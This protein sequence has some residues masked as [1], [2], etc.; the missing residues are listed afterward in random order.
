VVERLQKLYDD[1]K[2]YNKISP[3]SG[4][5]GKLFAFTS[6]QSKAPRGVYLYGSVGKYVFNYLLY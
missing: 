4:V 5:L 1:V 3:S 6:S 2:N